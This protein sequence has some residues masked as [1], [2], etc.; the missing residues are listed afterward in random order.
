MG[1]F[2]RLHETPAAF[3]QALRFTEAESGFAQRLVEKDYYCSLILAD[4]AP[5]FSGGLVFKGGTCLG[6]VYAGFYRLSENLDFAISIP[7]TARPRDRREARLPVK[8]H[9]EQIADRLPAVRTS[10][11]PQGCDG[12][13][14][15]NAVLQYESA[16]TGEH[17][18]VKVQVAIREPII[19]ATVMRTGRTLLR[20][21][22]VSD[23]ELSVRVLSLRETYAEKVRAA[24]TRTPP[25]IRDVFDIDEAVR[26]ER[27]DLCETGFISLVRQKLAVP[28]CGAID[29]G[30]IRK[31]LL[32]DQLETHLKPVLRGSDYAAFDIDRAFAEVERLATLIRGV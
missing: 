1:Q 11:P 27:L 24:L 4:F 22:V 29:T 32:V 26:A 9:L 28:G 3:R 7:T 18:T 15:Y 23:A 25:A 2:L 17:E 14:Q 12:N 8:Q 21:P 5:L 13:R 30:R 31:K 10:D 20:H 16:V 6:K 19:E